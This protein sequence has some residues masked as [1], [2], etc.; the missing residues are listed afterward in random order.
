MDFFSFLKPRSKSSS[1]DQ[2]SGSSLLPSDTARRRN[3][4]ST[5]ALTVIS[6]ILSA[7]VIVVIVFAFGVS[8]AGF[9]VA[10]AG[11]MLAGASALTGGLAGFLFGIPRTGP[12]GKVEGTNG[13]SG[14][15]RSTIYANTNLEQIS[16]WLT[17]IIVG[18]GL[19]EFNRIVTALGD[20]GDMAKPAFGNGIAGSLFAQASIIFFGFAGFLLG[21]LWTR[22]FLYQTLSD[23]EKGFKEETRQALDN[24]QE[25][26]QKIDTNPEKDGRAIAL[27]MMQLDKGD[28]IKPEALR[29]AYAEASPNALKT[30]FAQA[31]A[32][33]DA[34]WEEGGARLKRCIPVFEALTQVEGEKENPRAWGQLGSIYTD[35]KPPNWDKALEYLNKA[36]EMRV[37]KKHRNPAWTY[38]RLIAIL[39]KYAEVGL[40]PELKEKVLS[41]IAE[42]RNKG[43]WMDRI[44]D[45]KIAMETLRKF[46]PDIDVEG[47]P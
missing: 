13:K 35:T 37:G 36:M 14:S 25:Q 21:F 23:L 9:T 24:L 11:L 40:S 33:Q 2:E 31:E 38:N 19:V 22:I 20:F 5:R 27:T 16:D 46:C 17:K 42:L 43:P 15:A 12:E 8:S 32:V 45:D 30:I 1:D 41:D 18:V 3:E 47:A 29:K 7:G 4:Y 39:Y 6:A 34:S 28:D 26:F 10:S 44:R